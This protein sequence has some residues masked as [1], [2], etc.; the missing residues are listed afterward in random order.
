MDVEQHGGLQHHL[1]LDIDDNLGIKTSAPAS[2]SRP[3]APA[4]KTGTALDDFNVELDELLISDK[5][6]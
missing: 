5:K 2:A 6:A 3:A 1:N 4:I